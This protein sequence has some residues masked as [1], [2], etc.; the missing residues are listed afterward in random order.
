MPGGHLAVGPVG[1]AQVGGFVWVQAVSSGLLNP[2]LTKRILLTFQG[3]CLN[4]R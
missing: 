1:R 3:A 4:R 2:C